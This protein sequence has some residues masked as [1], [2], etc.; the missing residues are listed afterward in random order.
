MVDGISLVD[1]TLHSEQVEIVITPNRNIVL[2][3]D[4]A[5]NDCYDV[6]YSFYKKSITI[7]IE[8]Q[9]LLFLMNHIGFASSHRRRSPCHLPRTLN[10]IQTGPTLPNPLKRNVA[11][12]ES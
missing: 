5:I 12:G 6:I 7:K 2:E 4:I 1:V 3:L 9:K 10:S 11:F 8:F